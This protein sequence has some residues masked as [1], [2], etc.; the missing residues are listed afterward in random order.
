MGS[1]PKLIV[2]LINVGLGGCVVASN[3]GCA[4]GGRERGFHRVAR[5]NV[6]ESRGNR[7]CVGESLRIEW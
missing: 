6:K 4:S 3:C 2:K 7:E 1:I 5:F